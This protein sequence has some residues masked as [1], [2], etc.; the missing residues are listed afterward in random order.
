[1]LEQYQEG[2][3]NVRETL[4]SYGCILEGHFVGTSD[5]HLA[6]YC[7]TDPLLPHTNELNKLV[8]QMVNPF[9]DDGVETVAATPY[10]S[11]PFAHIGASNLANLTGREIFGIFADKQVIAGKKV[12][13]IDRR[14][15][16][17][18]VDG[19][20]VLVLEDMINRM[21]SIK[22]MVQLIRTQGGIVIGVGSIAANRGVTAEAI[23]VPKL[24]TLSEIYYET[25]TP[26]EC[27]ESGLCSRGEPIIT[28]I[29]HGDKFQR[30]NPDYAGGYRKSR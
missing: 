17:E 16:R 15:F 29:G 2:K 13:N 24:V 20:K 27:I 7:D 3:L 19:K 5:N 11:T 6:G 28:D 23:G 12:F 14:G 4:E 21:G 9:K 10:G 8:G 1:M 30:E 18:A 26:E 22:D 25:W